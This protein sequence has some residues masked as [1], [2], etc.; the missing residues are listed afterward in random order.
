M[1]TELFIC[2]AEQVSVLLEAASSGL[3]GPVWL[4]QE[5]TPCVANERCAAAG[6]SHRVDGDLKLVHFQVAH[7]VVSGVDQDLVKDLVQAWHILD[8][9]EHQLLPIM[10]PQLLLLLLCAACR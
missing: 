3:Q 9:L 1:L 2:S 5:L 4:F 6:R 8:V 10:H 7:F